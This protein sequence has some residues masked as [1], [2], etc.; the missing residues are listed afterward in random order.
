MRIHGRFV[1]DRAQLLRAIGGG[2]N[3][4]AAVDVRMDGQ[5]VSVRADMQGMASM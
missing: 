5:K 1:S 4:A 3:E 2:C